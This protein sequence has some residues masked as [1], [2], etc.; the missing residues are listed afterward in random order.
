[1]MIVTGMGRSNN[2]VSLSAKGLDGAL[3]YVLDVAEKETGRQYE[4]RGPMQVGKR[5]QNR[6]MKLDYLTLLRQVSLNVTLVLGSQGC[7]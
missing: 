1:M 5:T 2:F 6:I 4:L 3:Q 7:T